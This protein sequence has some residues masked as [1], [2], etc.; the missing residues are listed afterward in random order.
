LAHV[1]LELMGG[2]QVGL[3]L[4]AEALSANVARAER[5]GPAV[6]PEALGLELVAEL[7]AQG[8]DEILAALGG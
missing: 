4:S 1:Y 7:R 6:E 8:A 3:A 2:R 5:R